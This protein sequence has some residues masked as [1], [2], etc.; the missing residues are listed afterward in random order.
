MSRRISRADAI[1]V[2][3]VYPEP[4]K[5]P[6]PPVPPFPPMPPVPPVPPVPPPPFPPPK[7]GKL[8]KAIH[9][10]D[11]EILWNEPKII[12]ALLHDKHFLLGV[13]KELGDKLTAVI[14]TKK[15]ITPDDPASPTVRDEMIKQG[16]Q[17]GDVMWW[18]RAEH[19]TRT[20]KSTSP[21][22]ATIH[23]TEITVEVPDSAVELCIA[24]DVPE[25]WHACDG[26]A[27][28]SCSKYPELAK[29]FGGTQNEDG[30]WNCDGNNV[31][32]DW[33]DGKS[34][35]AR[36]WIPYLEHKIIKVKYIE[37]V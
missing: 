19:E 30:S 27:I 24:K 5:A 3:I 35:N 8:P 15:D 37:E 9:Y 10:H 34:M 32:D 17:V 36:I 25:Y 4:P 2:A 12:G 14:N 33:V 18:E 23:G 11:N 21:F 6:P 28:L 22:T 13:I 20:V 31:A 7:P 1:P 16:V 29:F 26:R